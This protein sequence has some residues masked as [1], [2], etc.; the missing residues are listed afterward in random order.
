MRAFFAIE[1][2]RIAAYDLLTGRLQW[3]VTAHP[4]MPPVAGGELVFIET[5][6]KY[7]VTPSQSLQ[8]AVDGMFGEETYY[9]K[10]DMSLP[11]RQKRVWERKGNG[12][13]GGDDD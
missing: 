1:G 4:E 8:Q 5:H 3:L 7:H 10:A 2:D 11:E 6:D 12:N 13:G 9:A